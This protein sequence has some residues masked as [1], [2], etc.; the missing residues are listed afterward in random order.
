MRILLIL[1]MLLFVSGCFGRKQTGNKSNST[2]GQA[3]FPTGASPTGEKLIVTP[4]HSLVGKVALVNT[5]DR[6]VVLNFP[7]GHLPALEQRLNLYRGGLK[8]GEV[9]VTGP[10]YDDN[11]VGD[12]VAG[13]SEVGDEVRDK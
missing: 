6:F 9:K 5:A 1:A 7:V 4:E 10:Q 2:S 12:L 8:V 3:S 13:D 11:V